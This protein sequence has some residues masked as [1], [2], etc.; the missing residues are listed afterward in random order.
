MN[1]DKIGTPVEILLVEDNPG[2]V[3][4]IQRVLKNGEVLNNLSVVRD[5]EEAL[6]FL[7]QQGKYAQAPFPA[8]IL[9][10]LN[11]PKK[12]GY[13]VLAE[14][15]TDNNLK[16][17]PVVILTSSQAEE[18]ILRVY[19]LRANCYITKPLDA[20]EFI[21]VIK[22]IKEFWLTIVKLPPG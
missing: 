10:D 21:R 22:Y 11:L 4:F 2:D 20:D 1:G 17:I 5:G 7:R 19:N 12:N 16:H 3:F 18:D 15:K 8:L 14:V 13:E 9:L 6:N